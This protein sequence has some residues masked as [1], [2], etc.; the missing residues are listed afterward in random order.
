MD[1]NDDYAVAWFINI[2]I[3]QLAMFGS[4]I[5]YV[6]VLERI[7]DIFVVSQLALSLQSTLIDNRKK[8]QSQP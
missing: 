3:K 1:R 7:Y 2:L 6:H 4:K 8:C 5:S